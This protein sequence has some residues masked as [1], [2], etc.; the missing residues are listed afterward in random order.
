MLWFGATVEA[1]SAALWDV[2]HDRQQS[3]EF[4]GLGY[5]DLVTKS[6]DLIPDALQR[7]AEPSS[8]DDKAPCDGIALR[9]IT[10]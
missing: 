2:L 9:L 10:N 8:V 4:W 3:F 6:G 5:A 7:V 1:D